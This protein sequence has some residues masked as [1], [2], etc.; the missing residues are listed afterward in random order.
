MTESGDIWPTSAQVTGLLIQESVE[1]VVYA[2]L[3][4]LLLY[5]V[6]AFLCKLKMYKSK[7]VIMF[8]TLALLV[9]ALRITYFILSMFY[10]KQNLTF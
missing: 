5:M 2:T 4:I 9:T 3:F 7:H 1:L 6:F 8:Y 10:V